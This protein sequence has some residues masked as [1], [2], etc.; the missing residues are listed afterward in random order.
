MEDHYQWSSSWDGKGKGLKG[1]EDDSHSWM[2]I[3]PFSMK[4]R[5]LHKDDVRFSRDLVGNNADGYMS[6]E[7]RPSLFRS[8]IAFVVGVKLFILRA[9]RNRV[10]F[11]IAFL[12]AVTILVINAVAVAIAV[13]SFIVIR[14]SSTANAAAEIDRHNG[15]PGISSLPTMA[16]ITLGLM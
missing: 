8:G 9:G 15:L 2:V 12:I 14:E 4:Q 10:A 7:E 6:I 13:A 11:L 16:A 3:F 1:G 5:S